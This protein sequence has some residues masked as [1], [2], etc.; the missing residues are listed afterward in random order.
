M[1]S[2]ERHAQNTIN[3]HVMDNNNN[4]TTGLVDEAVCP[5]FDDIPDYDDI[6][7]L[8]RFGYDL[9][10]GDL[11]PKC[12]WCYLSEIV[13]PNYHPS[14]PSALV[15]DRKGN[16][17]PIVFYLDSDS[18][19]P[20][21]QFSFPVGH[22]IALLYPHKK[23][24]LDLTQ[25]I[26]VEDTNFK[27][28]KCSLTILLCESIKLGK[29]SCYSCG[30]S[31]GQLLKCGKCTFA[32][33][34]SKTC[35]TS[36]WKYHKRLCD[37]IRV[38]DNL[39]KLVHSPYQDFVTMKDLESSTWSCATSL[40]TTD[41]S[42]AADTT[43]TETLSASSL[44]TTQQNSKP[45][46]F[47]LLFDI[48]ENLFFDCFGDK[49][50]WKCE[51]QSL[52]ENCSMSQLKS[53]LQNP[54]LLSV[55]IQ[56]H[57]GLYL[58]E[59]VNYYKNGGF[60]VY[61]GIIGEFA[62]PKKLSGTFDLEWS[63]SAY[64]KFEYELTQVGKQ[65][66][67]DA[68][69]KQKY[70]KSNLLKVPAADRILVPKHYYASVEELIQDEFYDD[71]DIDDDLTKQGQ[72]RY[73]AIR[74]ELNGQVPLALHKANHGGRIAYLGFVNGDDNIPK[75]VQALCMGVSTSSLSTI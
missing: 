60:I 4:S 16:N 13:M 59:I 31:T 17:H 69:T 39:V 75:L 33:Y 5:S 56:D 57:E 54:R 51:F 45:D 50:T 27:V 11:T 3:H 40:S 6:S 61:F 35:Q 43:I 22:T 71:G 44:S 34:C 25:G 48:D 74:E 66:L 62:A 58:S 26:R 21:N 18:S 15:Q 23:T 42:R 70:S 41:L 9:N 2:L 68:I 12:N 46:G 20:S 55:I 63:F 73:S 65:L 32:L 53:M 47:I 7:S 67:G 19:P 29:N 38:L 14:R 64:T 30:T 72:A 37:D 36:H 10:G 24:F 49:S 28:F 8:V 52:S 1:I